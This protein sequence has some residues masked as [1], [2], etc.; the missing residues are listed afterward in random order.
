MNTQCADPRRRLDE[1]NDRACGLGADVTY[2]EEKRG[3]TNTKGKRIIENHII[4]F[5]IIYQSY[6]WLVND[7]ECERRRSC[8]LQNTVVVMRIRNEV[9]DVILEFHLE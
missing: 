7:S 2:R 6:F 1:D 5:C 4:T 9:V 3:N 8:F